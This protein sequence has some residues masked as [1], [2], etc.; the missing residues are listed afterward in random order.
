MKCQG[1]NQAATRASRKLICKLDRAASVLQTEKD[2][3]SLRIIGFLAR[4]AI[5][6]DLSRAPSVSSCNL[7]AWY[8]APFAG[9]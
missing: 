1:K 6:F 7:F 3:Q 9:H 5:V 4:R 8:S 2:A